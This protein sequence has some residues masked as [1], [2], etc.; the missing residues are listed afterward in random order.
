[1]RDELKGQIERVTYVSEDS[2]YTVAK[3]KAYGHKDLVTIV[4]RILS[5]TP[6][7]ILTM[8]GEWSRHPRFGDQF[9]ITEYKTSVPASVNGIRKYLGSGLIKGIGPVMAGR[10][11]GQFGKETLDI[12]ENNPERLLEVE[13]IGAKRLDM[14]KKAWDDQKEIRRVMIFLQE[15]GVSSGYAAKIFKQ[16]GD[17]AVEIIKEDPYRLA[18][19]IHGIGFVSAD[20]IA[21]SL[22]IAKDAPIRA[23]AGVMYALHQMA[24]EGHVYYPYEPL[25][26][27]SRELL[28]VDRETVVGA[29]GEMSIGSNDSSPEIIIEDLNEGLENFIENHKAVY[30]SGYHFAEK[31]T[32][33][34]LKTLSTSKASLRSIDADRA[35]DWVQNELDIKLAPLQIE[36]VKQAANSKV[37]VITGGPGTGKTTIIKAIL[38]IYLRLKAEVLL[39]APTGRAAKRMSE[40]TGIEAKTIHRLL[41]FAPG[42]G[43]FKKNEQS[44]LD[45]DL[46][47]VDES[48]M[49]DILLMH[50]LL[51]AV[52]NGATLILVGDVDQLPSV[53]PGNVLSD[54]IVSG[55]APVV[56]LEEIFRQARESSIIVNAHRINQGM[57][58][59]APERNNELD[60]FYFIEKDQ[61]E[62]VLEIIIELATERIPKR[63]GFDPLEDIQVLTPMHR[64]PAGSANLNVELQKALNPKSPGINRAGFEFRVN[65][66]IMQTRNNYDK[67]VFNGDIGRIANLD[68]EAKSMEVSFDGR[69][70]PYDF[71]DLDEIVP[72]YAIS[73]HK[74]QGS[75]YPAVIVPVL[76]QHYLLLQRNLFYTAVTRGKDLVIMVGARKALAIALK[77][78]GTK[79]RYTALA[80]RLRVA[81]PS[82]L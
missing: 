3:V 67:E 34:R 31:N 46:L 27:K 28:G 40:T 56:K 68:Y 5:P 24:D 69:K 54:I 14:I 60:D 9:K 30:L 32:A 76:T 74:S 37:L 23:R 75:E 52:P 41:E 66:K 29:I 53:G 61:P 71:S 70:L 59:S 4:G 63:F 7:E 55:R 78:E 72:A 43:G 64:G 19:D 12:I 1:M 45:C 51:K 15:H 22:D 25:V 13:G 65:D 35:A 10:L 57:H 82:L 33:A 11:V 81:A 8:K 62:D 79:K 16:Y 58:P 6:G 80:G 48:S 2:G 47:I 39:A 50:N 18:R 77:N 44:P 42:K 20:R 38:T 26:E 36:A 49:I 21:A 17:E 73:V